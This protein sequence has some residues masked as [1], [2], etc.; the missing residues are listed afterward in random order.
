M[1]KTISISAFKEVLQAEKNNSS[2]DFINVCEPA[3]YRE[4]HIDGVRNI[5]LGEVGN[6]IDEL[7]TKETIYVHC[8]SGAR[9][10]RAIDTLSKKGLEA[11]LINVEGGILAW[12]EAGHPTRTLSAGLPLMRQVF[13]AAGS[14]IILGF[15]GASLLHPAMIYL[16]LFVGLGLSVS[17]ATGWC[18]MA[19]LLSKMPWNTK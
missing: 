8:R 7:A 12:D 2:V 14:L 11:D 9:A 16:A 4:K 3:E 10:Q 15:I 13:L 17:G 1:S 6:H 18:G 5:P 19:M